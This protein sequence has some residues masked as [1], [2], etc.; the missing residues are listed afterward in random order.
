MR[1][2]EI[3]SPPLTHDDLAMFEDHMMA[4]YDLKFFNLQFN[5]VGDILLASIAVGHRKQG[6]GTKVMDELCK[7]A[8]YYGRRIALTPDRKN[9][10]SGT[11]SYNRLA[12]FYRRF[13]FTRN[14]DYRISATLI[15]QPKMALEPRYPELYPA[16]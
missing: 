6:T 9:P 8:D 14:T 7:F 13:G 5:W 15:R 10:Q 4:T 12:R 3:S 11:T 16:T 2:H 1:F